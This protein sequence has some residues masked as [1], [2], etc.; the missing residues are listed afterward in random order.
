MVLSL[1]FG[2]KYAKGQVQ[3]AQNGSSIVTFDTTISEDHKFTS[4]VTFFPIESGTIVSDH[5]INQPDVVTISGF[6]TD[7]SFG[8]LF[9]YFS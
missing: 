7:F 4:R 1:I 2:K 6:V 3:D 5:I 8:I 9:F